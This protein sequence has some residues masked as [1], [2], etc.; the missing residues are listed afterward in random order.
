MAKGVRVARPPT[1]GWGNTTTEL[2]S[3]Q[4]FGGRHG[5]QRPRRQR[6]WGPHVP[7]RRWSRISAAVAIVVLV[8]VNWSVGHALTMTGGGAV[9]QRLAEW[10]RDHYLG[11]L[12]TLGEWMTYQ[13]PKAGG[14][15]AF[16]LTGP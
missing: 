2:R 7:R 12:V 9:S 1:A 5:T 3:S 4:A 13:P 16:A 10:A 8:P 6:N 15:P 14:K 11:P